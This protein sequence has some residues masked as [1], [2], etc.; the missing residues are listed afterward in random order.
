[1]TSNNWHDLYFKVS[2]KAESQRRPKPPIIGLGHIAYIGPSRLISVQRP[3]SV[4][5][6]DGASCATTST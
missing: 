5:T 4:E 3:T 2:P 6:V 1:M